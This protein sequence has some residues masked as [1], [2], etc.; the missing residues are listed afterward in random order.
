MIVLALT[1]IISR[2]ATLKVRGVGKKFSVETVHLNDSHFFSTPLSFGDIVK[3]YFQPSTLRGVPTRSKW[4]SAIRRNT[5]RM[6]S[7]ELSRISFVKIDVCRL[8]RFVC[9]TDRA[10]SRGVQYIYLSTRRMPRAFTQQAERNER[11]ISST[12]IESFYYHHYTV[13]LAERHSTKSSFNKITTIQRAHGPRGIRRVKYPATLPKTLNRLFRQHILNEKRTV[14]SSR[15]KA[16]GLAGGNRL[17]SSFPRVTGEGGQSLISK[18]E[19]N[20]K[21][22]THFSHV[23]R[24]DSTK[25]TSTAR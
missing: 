7:W 15:P 12:F 17:E 4:M 9:E 3:I 1:S 18:N 6:F 8:K 5:C 19:R 22:S 2:G 16:N 23:P 20:Y 21:N 14:S 24:S 10:N 13:N 25:V 11:K